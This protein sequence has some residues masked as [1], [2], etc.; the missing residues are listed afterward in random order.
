VIRSNAATYRWRVS[1]HDLGRQLGSRI[2]LVPRLGFE[3]VANGLLV[4]AG[5]GPARLVGGRVPE[6]ARVGRHDFVDQDQ[7]AG[8]ER[9]A[10]LELGVGQQDAGLLGDRGATR[11]EPRAMSRT[12]SE[13][14]PDKLDHRVE[15]DVLVVPDFGLGRRREDRLW[16]AIGLAQTRGSSMPQIAPLR[17]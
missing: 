15:A 16:Q 8:I 14:G 6:A 5:L 13:S 1:G 3:P 10:Q 11:V 9:R 7:L 2:G 4:E 17:L 12:R